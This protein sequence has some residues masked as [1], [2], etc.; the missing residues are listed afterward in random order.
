MISALIPRDFRKRTLSNVSETRR[1]ITRTIDC[2]HFVLYDVKEYRSGLKDFP[3]PVGGISNTSRPP[4]NI[5]STSRC[6]SIWNVSEILSRAKAINST[7]S[8]ILFTM[9]WR[10]NLCTYLCPTKLCGRLSDWLRL[11]KES[12]H[13]QPCLRGRSA[14]SFP[15]QRLVIGP[16]I[17][18]ILIVI[19]FHW[20]SYVSHRQASNN[21]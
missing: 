19:L 12:S 2:A 16:N 20:I 3:D 10:D 5:S 15:E 9:I 17:K 11:T 1:E 4:T 8:A 21:K 14:G 7:L 6:K 18:I 13:I